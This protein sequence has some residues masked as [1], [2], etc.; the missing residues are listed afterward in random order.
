VMRPRILLVEDERIVALAMQRCLT[1]LGYDVVGSASHADEAMMLARTVEPD[2]VLMDIHLRDGADG[3]ETARA[4]RAERDVPV[5]FL[6]AHSDDGTIAR[7]ASA[8]AAGYVI[9]PYEERE[10]HA[11]IAAALGWAAPMEVDRARNAE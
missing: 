4:I 3:I 2:V 6:T 5:V 9:K 7:A 1:R 8:G 10:L 11:R